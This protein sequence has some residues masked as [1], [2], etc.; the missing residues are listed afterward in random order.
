MKNI[1]LIGMSGVGKT[2]IG[3]SLSKNLQMHLMD[4]DELI[5]E[6]TNLPIEKIFSLHGESYFR[7]IESE[8][9]E[10][11]SLK[12][13]LIIS[14]G[15]GIV[16]DS[17]NIINLKKNGVLILLASSIDH[18]VNNLKSSTNVRPLLSGDLD[19]YSRVKFLYNKRSKL[20]ESSADF[21]ISVDNKSI[22][23]VVFQIIEVYARISY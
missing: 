9:V 18:I 15:G 23:E 22:D 20:Y 19:I 8:I 2:T 1:V 12:N 6:K 16:L 21:T 11:L 14:T 3:R 7:L 10:K 13:N 5:E 17:K 4:T